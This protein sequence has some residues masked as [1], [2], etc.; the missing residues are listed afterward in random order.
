MDDAPWLRPCFHGAV[1][2][3]AKC[4]QAA[5]LNRGAEGKAACRGSRGGHTLPAVLGHAGT[6]DAQVIVPVELLQ[7]VGSSRGLFSLADGSRPA[8]NDDCS[9]HAA[10]V[11]T[12]APR[13]KVASEQAPCQ[14]PHAAAAVAASTAGSASVDTGAPRCKVAS[15]QV[16]CQ[17]PR[18]AAAV[19]A[20]T[21]GSASVDT[22]APRCKLAS[23]QVLCQGPHATWAVELSEERR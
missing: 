16:L 15:E 19:A 4:S 14:G 2:I 20:R 18:A 6:S 17:G 22:G 21:A 5:G 11:D 7:S 3:H 1:R 12:G 10:S 8:A 9:A 23:E 13:C